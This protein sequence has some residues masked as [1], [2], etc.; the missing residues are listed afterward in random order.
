MAHVLNGAICTP[1]FTHR[2]PGRTQS[3]ERGIG[4]S[5]PDLLVAA[6]DANCSSFVEDQNKIQEVLRPEFKDC[7][8]KATPDP[9]IE[10]WFLAD[11]ETFHA[12]VGIT[13]EFET[14]KCVRDYYKTVLAKAVEEAGHPPTLGGIE[15]ARELVDALDYYRAGRADNSLKHFLEDIRGRFKTGKL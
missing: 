12:V 8:V 4:G 6:I 1:I 15:F 11:L 13:P 3:F 10:R 7:T 9:H 14:G 5:V 2:K